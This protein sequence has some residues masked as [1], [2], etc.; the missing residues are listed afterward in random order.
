MQHVR[1]L[2]S[3][4]PACDEAGG[5]FGVG[6]ALLGGKSVTTRG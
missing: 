2:E 1:S 4:S 6:L 3:K 5:A